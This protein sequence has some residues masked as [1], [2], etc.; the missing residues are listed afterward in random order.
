MTENI[1]DAL[2]VAP[3]ATLAERRFGEYRDEYIKPFFPKDR[4]AAILDIACGP[5]LF[6]DTCRKLGYANSEGVD[7]SAAAVEYAR[8]H[9]N[10]PN[11]H[12]GNLWDYLSK[13]SDRTFDIITAFNILEHI[14]KERVLECLKLIMAKLK[15]G[16]ILLAEVPNG[17][18]LHGVAT[19]FS[20]ITHEFAF[21]ARLARELLGNA[22]FSR[23]TVK[24]K[25]V[26]RNLLIRFG[27]KIIAKTWGLDD[28]LMFSGNLVVIAEK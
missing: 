25:F 28:K 3:A 16:G 1:Y 12:E 7:V 2:F 11:V 5:G 26:N 8:M 22:G 10:L 13:K 18:S 20:D 15:D 14:P 17:E 19:F 24:P 4:T 6:L 9:F 23:A 27:Q 21:T